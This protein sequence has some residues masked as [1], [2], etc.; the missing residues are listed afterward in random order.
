MFKG[1][2]SISVYLFIRGNSDNHFYLPVFKA[3]SVNVLIL[4]I[5]VFGPK[6]N[7][8]K[9]EWSKIHHEELNDQYASSNIV[10]V[11]NSRR[12]RWA[13]HVARMV[14]RRGVYKVLVGEPEGK[15]PLWRPRCRWEDNIKMNLQELGCRGNGLDRAGS[16]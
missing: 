5:A 15:K 2:R 1:R 12:M 9:G 16:G 11:I 14:E 6:R 7:E 10:R 3:I 4:L 8:V 13:G